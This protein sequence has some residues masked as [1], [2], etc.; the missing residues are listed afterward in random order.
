MSYRLVKTGQVLQM[1]QFI[2]FTY[3]RFSYQSCQTDKRMKVRTM[4]HFIL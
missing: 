1:I 4:D 2:Y 3:E